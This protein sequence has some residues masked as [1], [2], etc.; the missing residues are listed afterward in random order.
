MPHSLEPVVDIVD[1][2]AARPD[3]IPFVHG[4]ENPD[5]RARRRDA[6]Q[7]G[8]ELAQQRI[9]LRGVAGAL[10]LKFARETSLRL[11][12]GHDRVDLLGRA[13][14]DG[15]ARS[16]VDAHLQA[17]EVGEHRL[18]FVGGVLDERHQPD[19]LAEQHR[20]ALTHQVRA[21]AD[22]AGGVRE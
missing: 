16:G 12:A 11:A 1:R 7:L 15:L 19:V 2:L 20:L 8:G 14:D 6:L 18:E 17:G 9:H 3:V 5:L 22:H 21:R 4:R 10:G 13:A